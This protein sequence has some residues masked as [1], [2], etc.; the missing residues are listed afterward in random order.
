MQGVHG[1]R[2]P[3]RGWQ[4][5]LQDVHRCHTARSK[6]PRRPCL[7][8]ICSILLLVA[9]PR[10]L[11][12][13]VL[14]AGNFC[15][16]GAA[17][18]L[19]CLAGT[20]SNTPG[21]TAAS[22][23]T[24]CPKGSAC[25]TGSTAHALCAP[26][27]IAPA[28]KAETCT[29]C[30]AGTFQ[31]TAGQT[32]CDT[33]TAGS[34]CVAAAAAALPCVAGTYSNTPGL[35]AASECTDCPK[36]S[37]C[38]TGSTAHTQCAPGTIAPA[39]KSETCANC[40][41]GTFQDTAGQTECD[42]CTAGYYCAAG[43][44]AA[45]PC[46]GGT[47][48]PTDDSIVMSSASQCTVCDKGTFCP[49]GSGAPTDCAPGTFNAQTQQESCTACT[50]GEY[51]DEAGKSDCKT[52]TG[53]TRHDQTTRN[54]CCCVYAPYL[55]LIAT[56][57]IPP[58][59]QPAT[60]VPLAP[61]RRCLAWLAPTRIQQ[62]S[63]PPV[64]ALTARRGQHAPPARRRMR[65]VLRAQSRQLSSLRRAP[66]VLLAPSKIRPVRLSATRALR[67]RSAWQLP[68]RRCLA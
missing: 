45:L 44:A 33:C 50:A 36:G 66:T 6:T 56:C 60:S 22:E 7:L 24:D 58:C 41:G 16:A 52:C 37:A 39:L 2:V 3:G 23:C 5:R 26:G 27:T 15:A 9:S 19:P 51:Q 30:T 10:A 67:A 11:H 4:E 28:L 32:E 55:L 40:A 68:P 43:A 57:L 25:S 35:T 54:A 63:K 59:W 31:D 17:A 64:S 47:H 18:A 38:S 65:Y 42:G 34:F 20:Y 13:A 14:A 8:R 61:P 53:A 62:A 46:P 49:V 48:K 29:D 12:S 1:W 21:L